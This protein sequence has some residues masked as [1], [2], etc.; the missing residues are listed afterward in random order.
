VLQARDDNG[1]PFATLLNF[2]AHATVLGSGNTHVTGDWVQARHQLLA[3]RFG[4]DAMTVV[5]TLGRTQPNRHGCPDVSLMNDA[6]SLC[7]IGDY[8]GRVVD[9]AAQAADAATPLAGPP[10]VG[11]RSYLIQDV[12]SNAILLGLVYTGPAG[13]T[14]TGVPLNRSI[15]PPWLAGN[16]IGTITGSV[17]IGDV[18]LSA[19]P[20]EAYPQI[21]L[22]VA[23]LATAPR[24]YMT[25]GLA[26]D[27][28]GYLIAPYQAYPEPIRRSFFTQQGD[29]INPIDNDNYFFNVSH[30]M[31]ERVNC[32]L[33][34]GAGD[35]FG[36][37]TSYRD[38]DVNC[39]PFL[40]DL[41]LPSGADA[42]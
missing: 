1:Q 14:T 32:S 3:Q 6:K 27:Q 4:G 24:G 11:T 10:T 26:N 37:G 18:L 22:N 34:R 39:A 19:I 35:L 38:A 16:V 42:G 41:L 28:L 23:G 20:G 21:A 5:G 30:T 31:G 13:D 17:R 2:S 9:R 25:A 8:A 15:T 40:N 7:E 33:L 29:Q 12:T 36:R